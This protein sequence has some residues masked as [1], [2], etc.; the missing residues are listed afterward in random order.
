MAPMWAAIQY[1]PM[2]WD[3]KPATEDTEGHLVLTPK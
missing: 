1:Y 3:E 2:L